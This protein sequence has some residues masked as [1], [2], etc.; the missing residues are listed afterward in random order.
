[1][2]RPGVAKAPALYAL[3]FLSGVAALAYQVCWSRLLSLTFGSTVLS[4]S[5]VVAGFMGGM[6]L[7]AWLYHRAEARV[8]SPLR[9]YG[10]IEVGIGV[11]ALALNAGFERMPAALA[12]LVS[13]WPIGPWLLV[14]QYVLV[15]LALLPTAAL[16]GATYP[17]LC[18]SLIETR[19]GVDL[20]LGGLYGLNTVGAAAGAVISGF[21][22]IER[23]GVAHTVWAGAA[24][25]VAVGVVALA[26]GRWSANGARTAHETQETNVPTALPF[27]VSGAV[28]FG[29]GFA[30]LSY[31]ILWFR[32][33][34]YLFG[35]S[36]YALT[37]ML[38]VFLIGLGVGGLLLRRMSR[39]A[40]PEAD[41]ALSQLSI[42]VL[43]LLVMGVLT[44]LIGSAGFQQHYSAF[45]AEAMSRPWWLRVAI[46]AGIGC[47]VT[48]PATVAMGLSFPLAS[49]LFLGDVH[50]LGARLG[51]AVLLANLGSILGAVLAAVWILPAMGSLGGTRALASFNLGLGLLTLVFAPLPRGR[52][53][54]LGGGALVAAF[55]LQSIG[56]AQVVFPG[57]RITSMNPELAFQEEGDLATVQVWQNKLQPEQKAMSIDGTIIGVS[58]GV[59]YPIYNKQVL[60]AHLPMVLDTR[61]RRVLNIGLGSGSTL[62]SLTSHPGL[63]AIDTVEIN[64]GVVRGSRLFAESAA[65]R[66][67]RSHVY[68]DDVL[69]FLRF[70]DAPYDLVI[71]DGKQNID[72]SGSARL[73]SREFYEGAFRRLSPEGLL[74]QWIPLALLASDLRIVLRT[75]TQTFPEVDVFFDLPGSVLIV[76]GR[77]PLSGRPRMTG[78]VFRGLRVA[79]DLRGLS[80]RDTGELLA[81]WVAGGDD[82]RAL[83]GDGPVNTWDRMLLEFSAFRSTPA[84]MQGASA[85]NLRFLL[86]AQRRAAERGAHPFLPKDDAA[87]R[88]ANLL[89]EALLRNLTRDFQGAVDGARRALAANPGDP[90][91][92]D[93]IRNFSASI[94]AGGARP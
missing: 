31:E 43:A 50:R 88:S 63:E 77:V 82:L 89:R 5:A 66:D 60:L 37:T 1:M 80:M 12:S 57:G 48:L 67:P 22:L 18:R 68:V 25:N 75:V 90:A 85:T 47:A 44:A 20:H 29:S 76:A 4:A 34:R 11:T 84:Q 17:A 32:G 91:A 15:F 13:H 8:A 40:N 9:L 2:S 52:R 39:S 81:R 21:F 72:F 54:G 23:I 71:S 93:A 78:D 3:A 69:R 42:G 92:E 59:F 33:L 55:A 79:D 24:L 19:Q 28:L 36:T 62:E 53:A 6:G 61:I 49:R 51:T 30:T 26:L 58:R 74:V 35:N 86:E 83:L 41:L 10:A 94:Q 65:L 45:S 38:V 56:P 87:V 7:G 16:M 46:T 14:S 70:G 64:E 73:L 27:W